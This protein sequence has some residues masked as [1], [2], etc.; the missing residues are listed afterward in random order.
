MRA[1]GFEVFEPRREAE[2]EWSAHVAD[3]HRQ[4]MMNVGDKV[5]SWMMGANIQGHDPRVLIY[6]GGANVYYDRLQESS[7]AGFPELA[8]SK[9]AG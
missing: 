2:E 4:T 9:A 5:H 8:F 7:D 6:F 3:I 1:D